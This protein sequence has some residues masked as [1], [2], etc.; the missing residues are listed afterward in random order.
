MELLSEIREGFASMEYGFRPI[1]SLPNDYPAFIMREDGEYGV[2]VPCSKATVPINEH[3]AN[4]RIRSRTYQ[5][6]GSD[7]AVDYICLTCS[8]INLRYEFATICAQFVDA[9]IEGNDRREL[10]LN[11]QKWWSDWKSL[12]GNSIH[13]KSAYSIIAEMLVLDT[14]FKNDNT[15]TWSAI[16]AGSQDIESSS[17]CYEVKSTIKKYDNTVTISSQHQL[18]SEKPLYLFFCRL[19]KSILGVSIN[20]IKKSLVA[21]GYDDNLLETQL[22]SYGYEKYASSRNEKYKVLEK[23]MFTVD[24]D[25]PQIT[26]S[27]FKDNK[28]P[29]SILH[30]LYTVDLSGL[31]YKNW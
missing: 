31:P 9:G 20:D 18:R 12:L 17:A 4:C 25:F 30:I 1:N 11:P 19:E 24:D 15:V 26:L 10:L 27:S 22:E 14:L 6:S 5:L 13:D 2:A 29:E 16:T 21:H 28:L 23:K 7:V 8:M 3:F